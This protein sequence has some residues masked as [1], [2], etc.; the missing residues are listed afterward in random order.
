M[1]HTIKGV[2]GHPHP[3]N[4]DTICL[5]SPGHRDTNGTRHAA[6]IGEGHRRRI[7]RWGAKL[8][9]DPG[10]QGRHKAAT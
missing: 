5:L 10:T 6:R 7:A 9:N 3:T 4:P 2:C 8:V 1:S